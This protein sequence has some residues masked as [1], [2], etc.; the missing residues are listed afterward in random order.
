MFLSLTISS[1]L[2][3]WGWVVLGVYSTLE[4]LDEEKGDVPIGSS[5]LFFF[6]EFLSE[7]TCV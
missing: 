7:T 3:G 2:N 5:N 6:P 1:K 4:S